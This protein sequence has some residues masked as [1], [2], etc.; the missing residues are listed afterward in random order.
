MCGVFGAALPKGSG[1]EAANVAALGL[2]ALQHRGQESAGLAVS[3]GAELFVYKDLQVAVQV[4]NLRDV[5]GGL[6][7]ELHIDSIAQNA[8]GPLHWSVIN[9]GKVTDR[10]NAALE[11]APKAKDIRNPDTGKPM[12]RED[13][14]EIVQYVSLTVAS[15]YRKGRPT[16]ILSQT[17]AVL[18]P[19]R[20]LIRPVIERNETTIAFAPGGVGKS[21]F[22]QMLGVAATTGV[23]LPGGLKVVDRVNVLY[24]DWETEQTTQDQRFWAICRGHGITD[25][26]RIYY[27][28]MHRPLVEELGTLRLEVLQKNIGLVIIDSIS[29]A[30]NGDLKD[31][32]VVRPFMT[33]LRTMPCS[34]FAIAHVTKENSRR[35]EGKSTIFGS[36]FFE[37]G[38]RSTWEITNADEGQIS[39]IEGGNTQ[40]TY[41]LGL[42]NRKVN[43]GRKHR[44][45]GLKVTFVEDEYGNNFS[46]TYTY[47]DIESD[48][49]LMDREDNDYN[50]IRVLLK[51]N[52]YGLT[53]EEIATDLDM[54]PDT[55]YRLLK[56]MPDVG[57]ATGTGKGTIPARFQLM[58]EAWG[59]RAIS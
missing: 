55:T 21:M 20:F 2:F 33:G 7:G 29:F 22:A 44:P 1:T 26:P 8:E 5:F 12:R 19:P 11:V 50:R 32:K 51:K 56:K 9:L 10:K 57:T 37:A 46:T 14:E 31:D 30:M 15:E 41:R 35:T 13:W 42:F 27:R 48:G 53:K 40:T 38:A 16:T 52:P 49:M 47:H 23:S 28:E 45:V 58:A 3:D 24:L 6:Q 18:L 4:T 25:L 36:A 43:K 54:V 34:R 59:P 17:P 39:V